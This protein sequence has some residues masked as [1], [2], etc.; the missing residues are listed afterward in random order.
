MTFCNHPD[1]QFWP[2]DLRFADLVKPGQVF[3][4]KQITDLYLLGLAIRNGGKLATLD[5]RIPTVLLD[6][7]NEAL[8][9]IPV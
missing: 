2:A 6:Q 5:R 9:L 3:S 8:T 7:G 1:H 4:H